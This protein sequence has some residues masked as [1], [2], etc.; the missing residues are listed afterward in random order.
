MKGRIVRKV[1][2]DDGREYGF[3]RRLDKK[4]EK[5]RYFD[6][7]YLQNGSMSDFF[8]DDIVVFDPSTNPYNPEQPIA[9]NVVLDLGGIEQHTF[10]PRKALIEKQD[11]LPYYPPIQEESVSKQWYMQGVHPKSV[12][13]T[14]FSSEE[15]EILHKM[16]TILYH[17]NDGHFRTRINGL[18]YGYSLFGPTKNFVIQLGLEKVE[19]ALI[20]CDR[21]DFQRRTLEETFQYLTHYIIPK[22]RISGHFYVLV[23]KYTDIVRQIEEPEIQGALPYSIIP[24]S[25]D[26]LLDEPIETFEAFVLSRFKSH[27]FERD[28]FSYSEPINDRLFLFGGRDLFAKQIADRCV[29]GNHSGIFGLRKSGKTSVINMIKQEL[30]QRGVFFLSYR[31]IEFSR[32]NWNEAVYKIIKDIYEKV[33]CEL[34]IPEYTERDAVERFSTDLTNVSNNTGKKIV[35]IFDEIE[36][37]AVDTTYDEKWQNPTSTFLFWSALV[38]YFEKNPNTMSLVIAGINPSI[39]ETYFV[40]NDGKKSAPRNPMYKKLSNENYLKPFVFEQTRRMVNTL[41]KYMGFKFDDETCYELQKDFGGLP[42]FTRQMCKIIVEHVKRE[43]LKKED[44]PLF[45]VKRQLY[46]AVKASPAFEIQ[47]FEW[48]DNILKELK[49]CYP[50]EYDLLLKISNNDKTAKKEIQK[51]RMR[52]RILLVM[53]W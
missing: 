45:E 44:Q 51:I 43:K 39:N 27:L 34:P 17:T 42:F 26:E 12:Q 8:E 53:G 31:C 29:S 6:N 49:I 36:Q 48:C 20:F 11:S 23:T 15:V 10:V 16:E 50:K 21:D 4:E 19:F 18:N 28:F 41:G 5:D 9:K 7:R 22:V 37:I 25:Y 35:L 13:L 2:S 32:H 38:N 33:N 46:N 52:F 14:D 24:F 47:H 3:I 40:Q 30:E 1:E